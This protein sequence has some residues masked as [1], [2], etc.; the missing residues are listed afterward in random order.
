MKESRH[1]NNEKIIDWPPKKLYVK[2]ILPQL[3][4]KLGMMRNFVKA[5]IKK[6]NGFKY[7]K[8]KPLHSKDYKAQWLVLWCTEQFQGS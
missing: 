4:I 6:S 3:H 2:I 5:L 1:Q 7:L 8:A